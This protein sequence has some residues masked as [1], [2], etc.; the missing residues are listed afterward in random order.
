MKKEFGN[1]KV[2]PQKSYRMKQRFKNNTKLPNIK[3]LKSYGVEFGL[4][5]PAYIQ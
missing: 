4:K 2:G 1:E 5:T 3:E